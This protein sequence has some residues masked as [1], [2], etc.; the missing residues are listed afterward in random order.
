MSPMD[1][2]LEAFENI[3]ED[4]AALRE[5]I[6]RSFQE[7]GPATAWQMADRLHKKHRQ[8]VAPRISE[9][10]SGGKIRDTNI[11]RVDARTRQRGA[12]YA[13]AEATR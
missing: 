7:E 13:I 9:L 4:A 10:L 12:V 2:Q 3:Q 1:T 5:K 11:R 8:D 6:L